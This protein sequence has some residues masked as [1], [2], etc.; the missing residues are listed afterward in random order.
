MIKIT[1]VGLAA[2]ALAVTLVQVGLAGPAKGSAATVAV[3]QSD[4]GSILVSGRG[5]S[6]YLFDKDK[7]GKS[8]C[9][10]ACA[11]YW[12]PLLVS[13]KPHAGAGAKASLLGRTKRT[14]G[15]W[16]VTYK[17]HPLYTYSGDAKAGQTNGEGLDDFGATWDLVSPSG[18]SVEKDGGSRS[19]GNTGSGWHG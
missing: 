4:F 10:G 6:L 16:Q 7:G 18:A 12:P 13:G 5:R 14:D 11:A 3:G 9:Y 17:H 1:L 19:D 2:L 15:H 8:K